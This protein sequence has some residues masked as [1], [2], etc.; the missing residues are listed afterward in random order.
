MEK[1]AISTEY[2]KL[3]QFLKWTSITSSGAEAK[4]LISEGKFKVNGE[5]V[6]QRG[7][8]LRKGDIIEFEEKAFQID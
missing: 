2:I 7:K 8:K 4:T 3:D 1:I 6:L 5:Q